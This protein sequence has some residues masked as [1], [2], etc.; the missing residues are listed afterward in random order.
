MG[1]GEIFALINEN[2]PLGGEDNDSESNNQD[3]GWGWLWLIPLAPFIL[4]LLFVCWP[5]IVIGL[6]IIFCAHVDKK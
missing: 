6:I 1:I 5:L 3:S 2:K 4:A